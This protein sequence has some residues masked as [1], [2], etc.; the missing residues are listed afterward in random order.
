MKGLDMR[1]L[2]RASFL[3]GFLILLAG[4]ADIPVLQEPKEPPCTVSSYQVPF[5]SG[6]QPRHKVALDYT[7]CIDEAVVSSVGFSG[8]TS[9]AGTFAMRPLIER[10]FEL[11][12]KENFDPVAPGERPNVIIRVETK[13]LLVTKS[14]SKYTTDIVF[15]IKIIAVR[16]RVERR[17]F[18]QEYHLTE[19]SAE[20]GNDNTVPLCV[21]TCIQK[22]VKQ[23][24]D[25]AAAA[26]YSKDN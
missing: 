26:D 11:A 20:R 19:T 22:A 8:K 13:R 4:C 6:R 18:R 16:D 5:F 17:V 14:W 7:G 12:A 21:Y 10:E 23:F 1:T 2:G 3:V 25:D 24:L 9:M 15:D